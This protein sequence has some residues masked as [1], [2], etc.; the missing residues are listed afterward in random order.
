VSHQT[1]KRFLRPMSA[2]DPL[3]SHRAA[4]P[5]ELLTDLCFVVAVAQS[6][7]EFHHAL[8][9]NH[10]VAGL[11]SFCMTFFAIWWAWLNFTW[12]ASAYDNDDVPYRL[13][14]ILQIMGVLVLAGGIHRMYSGDFILGV[15]GY[16]IM[17]IALVAQWLRA[18]VHDPA[19]RKTC[20][21]YALGIVLV[22]VL[23]V[24]FLWVPQGLQVLVF[25]TFV[26]A[27]FAVPVFAERSGRTT[28]HPHHVAERYGLFFIIVLGETILSATMA[29][30]KT[31]NENRTDFQVLAV[32]LGGIL[33]LFSMWWLYF[34][35]EAGKALSRI[36]PNQTEA[37]IWGFGHYLVFGSG[38]A[39]G[40]GL[41]T[42]IDFWT[43]NQGASALASSAAVTVPVALLIAT[44]WLVQ[45]RP[46]DD[47][48][49]TWPPYFGAAVLVLLAT[50]TP[51]PEVVSGLICA[52][53]LVVELK[54]EHHLAC[55]S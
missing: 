54:A 37:F 12:F 23:W 8:S 27:E 31:L 24:G 10:I 33:I 13:L 47:T 35:R 21:A 6:A 44:L 43:M 2:R 7:A 48:V 39:I 11:L 28:W 16:V 5:L 32:V 15:I 50:F 45:V 26:V 51:A 20:R 49:R 42:R 46:H 29:V 17:R 34:S 9:A 22:Q 40:A 14:T 41:A 30:Q 1:P 18:S 19:H 4:S 3:E 36:G 52:L 38:A 25:F 55:E 53:L